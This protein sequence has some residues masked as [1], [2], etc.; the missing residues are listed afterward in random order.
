MTSS[1]NS[2]NRNR[3]SS[4]LLCALALLLALH[5]LSGS[6]LGNGE[7][8]AALI[9]AVV[10]G[11]EACGAEV[12]TA[13][14]E[15]RSCCADEAADSEDLGDSCACG[16]A[17]EFPLPAPTLLCEAPAGSTAG[18]MQ[19]FIEQHAAVSAATQD[20]LGWCADRAPG[21][22]SVHGPPG[23][24]PRGE[25]GGGGGA[26]LGLSEGVPARLAVLCTALV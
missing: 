14:V 11:C 8:L 7:G 13:A 24:R 5:P 20:L 15:S 6:A 23:P 10:C 18:S 12:E 26:P 17:A 1:M 21:A 16:H 2:R 19:A 25:D 4:A 22:T 9:K 3:R